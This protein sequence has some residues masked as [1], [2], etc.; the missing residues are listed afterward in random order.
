[1]S[2]PETVHLIAETSRGKLIKVPVTFQ[3]VKKRIE[4]IKCPFALKNEIKAMAGAKW[5]GYD[6][7]PRMIWSVLD[8][9]RNRFQLAFMQGKNP[10]ARWEKS[11]QEFTYERPLRQHQELMAN[12]GLTYHYCILA[13]EMGTGKTLS[14]I[15]IMEQSGFE[16]WW[17][18]GPK[19]ALKAV[20]REFIKWGLTGI[21]LKMMTYEALRSKVQNWTPG[22]RPPH[23]IVLDESSRLK[24]HRAKRSEAAQHLA[25]GIREAFGNDGY[26]IEMSGTPSPKSPVDWWSQ[27]E[28]AAPGFLREGSMK[29]FE[30]RMGIFVE[31][32]TSQ[33]K[34]LQRVA[35][36]DDEDKCAVCG[37]YKDAEQHSQD[38]FAE[39]YHNWEPSE[40]EVAYLNERLQGL[41][42]VLHKKDCLDLPEKHYRTIECPMTPTTER[43][44]KA[45]AKIA[46]NV[47]T[48]L[49]WLRELSDGFQ[50]RDEI[51]G[52]D[53][54]PICAK[55]DTPGQ[56]EVWCDPEDED[57]Q[58]EMV[59]MLDP[60][61]VETLEKKLVECPTCEGSTEVPHKIRVTREVPC[62]KDKALVEL[63]D[64]ND[65]QGRLVVFAGF[66]ASIDRITKL[67][68]KQKW[69][70]VKV[71]SRGWKV[72]DMDG[73]YLPKEDPLE[74]WADTSKNRRVAFVAHPQSG[75]MG[76]TLVESRMAV[77]YSN[78]FNPESR[79]QAED[80]IHRLGTDMN[81]GATIVDLIHLPTDARVR[82]ILRQNRKLELMTLGDLEATVGPPDEN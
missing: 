12:F 52:T 57:R 55:G 72:W 17:W 8:C 20:E 51:D 28:I 15:E 4:F 43:V 76:L 3:V 29:S 64:E 13:A 19:S 54:C 56:T 75:G 27:C 18:V 31:K 6:D 38:L 35:W 59:D 79:S 36:L 63:L 69:A 47:I 81:L 14:A 40:N 34:H 16:D 77:F 48:G 22:D 58:F 30:R 5:H 74:Y 67:C 62:P 33:G 71:D 11:L 50:Y 65:E 66:T 46:P 32:E 82:D 49:T 10:Y 21:D 23:G 42:L 39:D 45:L 53:P 26:V 61:Y 78:D 70:I 7:R 80:R 60:E 25:D 73:L 37:G 41:V 24:N 68:L 2:E 1:M 44:A 9:E